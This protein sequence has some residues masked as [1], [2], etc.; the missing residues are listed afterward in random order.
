MEILFKNVLKTCH[1]L[2]MKDGDI[3]HI[4]HSNESDQLGKIIQKYVV[5]G[6]AADQ[7]DELTKY[8]VLD[9]ETGEIFYK[10]HLLPEKD[11]EI[12]ILGPWT[13]LEL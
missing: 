10:L 4:I 3:G 12:E 11:I 5:Y 13:T 2:E 6:K 7:D 1:A 8:V 9:S